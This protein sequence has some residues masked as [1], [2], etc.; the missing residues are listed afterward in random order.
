MKKGIITAFLTLFVFSAAF[1]QERQ[2]ELLDLDLNPYENNKTYVYNV[3]GEWTH[4]VD[5][6][7][8]FFVFHNDSDE[9]IRVIG[10]I[11]EMTNTDGMNAQFC[12]IDLC[13]FPLNEGAFYPANGGV[14]EPD[15]YNGHL[16]TN[17][18]T[19]LDPTDMVEY[20]FRVF[21]QDVESGEEIPNTSFYVNY[22]YDED[23]MGVSDVQSPSIAELYP[24]VATGF[25]NVNLKENAHVQIYNLQ[26]KVVRTLDLKD[27]KSQINLSGLAAGVYMVSFKGETGTTTT[28]RMMVK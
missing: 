26:G 6:A 7:K 5:E 15:G 18:F 28:I 21:Q 4:E 3:H 14:I 24:T 23:A 16:G 11:L 17:Y 9:D 8:F 22:L 25:T 20:K 2:F 10:Q 1:G 13:Y 27:G 12:I 19:N